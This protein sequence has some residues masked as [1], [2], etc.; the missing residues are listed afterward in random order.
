MTILPSSQRI[1]GVQT[2]WRS[3]SDLVATR[4]CLDS[5]GDLERIWAGQTGN[6]RATSL[7]AKK[8]SNGNSKISLL[9]PRFCCSKV[10]RGSESRSSRSLSGT[11]W[12]SQSAHYGC[13]AGSSLSSFRINFRLNKANSF[14]QVLRLGHAV[15]MI[16]M[17][18]LEIFGWKK[19]SHQSHFRRSLWR[20]SIG[21]VSLDIFDSSQ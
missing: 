20:F 19:W 5:S 3:S 17:I 14:K 4:S 21:E 15:G 12:T 9:H 10:V 2:K 1:A 11:L 18:H 6:N 16:R 13:G 8:F 7:L